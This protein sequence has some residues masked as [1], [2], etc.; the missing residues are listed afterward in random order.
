MNKNRNDQVISFFLKE[1]SAEEINYTTIDRDFLGV[2]LFLERFR[3]LL[4]GWDIE[5]FTGKKVLKHFLWKKNLRRRQ[6][7][8]LD[9]FD[10]FGIFL[11]TLGPGKIHVSPNT[12]LFTT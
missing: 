2:I 11:T 12:D 6:E 1:I 7:K 5:I 10:N 8:L 9:T 3:C 4:E